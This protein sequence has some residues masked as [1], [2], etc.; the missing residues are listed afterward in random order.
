MASKKTLDR[1]ETL[2]WV[3]VYGGLLTFV[4]SLATSTYDETLATSLTVGGLGVA[5]VGLVLVYVRSRMRL[6]AS[7]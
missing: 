5:A 3:L 2:V 6:T 1:V 7:R 4:L